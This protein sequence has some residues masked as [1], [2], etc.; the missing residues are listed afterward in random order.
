MPRRTHCENTRPVIASL[1]TFTD[2]HEQLRTEW[3]TW[4]Q[5]KARRDEAARIED[6][7]RKFRTYR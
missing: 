6:L 4:M 3:A 1:A 5:F 7:A 2:L